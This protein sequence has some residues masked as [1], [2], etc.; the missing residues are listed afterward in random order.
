[1]WMLLRTLYG[2][3]D[4]ASE[5]DALATK[6][7]EAAGFETGWSSPCL[8]RHSSALAIGW[9]HGDDLV[10]AGEETF[11]E[12]LFAQLSTKL[13]LKR[14]A[15]L[16]SSPGDDKHITILNRFIDFDEQGTLWLEPDARHVD[17]LISHLDLRW[18]KRAVD[19]PCTKG[20]PAQGL[21]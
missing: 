4:A 21:P 15:L 9:R 17:L 12:Q 13:I 1:M 2:T 10:F 19:T 5:W 6:C 3:R 8:Y 16:G 20:L 7:L 11:L 18:A 14:R